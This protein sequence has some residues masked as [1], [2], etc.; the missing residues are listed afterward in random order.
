MSENRLTRSEEDRVIAGVC[1]GIANY[2]D[3]E[4]VW[5]RVLF[6]LLIL[7]SGMGLVIYLVL[8]FIMPL[9]AT[10]GGTAVLKENLDDLSQTVSSSARRIGQPGTLGVALVALGVF[11]LLNQLGLVGW[12]GGLFW[13]LLIIG[14]GIYLFSRRRA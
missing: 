13:P 3:V 11:F 10:V 14:V 9:E 4:S 2:L 6:G 8:W 7:A 1:G 12:L 5:V